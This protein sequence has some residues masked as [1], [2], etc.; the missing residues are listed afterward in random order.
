MQ[1]IING[2]IAGSLAVLITNP[3]D[4]AKTRLQLQGELKAHGTY[5]KHYRGV[6]DS[7]RKTIR[8]E[9]KYSV[10]KGL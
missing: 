10:Y 6:I 2:S 4:L 9:G 8:E 1:P 3:F 7:L 5:E